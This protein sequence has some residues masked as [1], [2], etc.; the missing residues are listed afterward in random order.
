VRAVN[1]YDDL[2][3]AA[4]CGAQ[5]L[6][7][8]STMIETGDPH[9]LNTDDAKRMR[10]DLACIQAAIA[11]ATGNDRAHMETTGEL[12]PGMEVQPE[13][14]TFKVTFGKKED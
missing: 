8:L 6:G 1:S 12:L 9:R 14:E 4:R 3:R 13:H 2:V 10:E 7:E 11:K 5:W